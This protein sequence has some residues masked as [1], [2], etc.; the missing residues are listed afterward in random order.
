MYNKD[1]N[2]LNALIDSSISEAYNNINNNLLSDTRFFLNHME[3]IKHQ[4]DILENLYSYV[5]QLSSTPPQ[6]HIISAFIHKIGYSDFDIETGNLLLDEDVYKR[7]LHKIHIYFDLQLVFHYNAFPFYQ[8]ENHIPYL[9]FLMLHQIQ[10]I[11]D[12]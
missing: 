6:A 7:Q 12:L 3:I 5:S 9:Y 1:L 8:H 10:L 11:H 2:T 4:R